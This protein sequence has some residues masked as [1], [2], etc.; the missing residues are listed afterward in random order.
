MRKII[1]LKLR[2]KES[3]TTFGKCRSKEGKKMFTLYQLNKEEKFICWQRF[4]SLDRRNWVKQNDYLSLK[5]VINCMES[6]K[7][8]NTN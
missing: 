2:N 6:N 3:I 1:V 4:E 5:D 7:A 8:L